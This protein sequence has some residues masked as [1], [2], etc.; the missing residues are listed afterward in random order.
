MQSGRMTYYTEDWGAAGERAV[1]SK[2]LNAPYSLVAGG[3]SPGML[4]QALCQPLLEL[5]FGQAG[6]VAPAEKRIR[7]DIG[8][9]EGR[10]RGCGLAFDF[11]QDQPCVAAR[12]HIDAEV[13]RLSVGVG[14]ARFLDR[15]RIQRQQQVVLGRA[16]VEVGDGGFG[17]ALVFSAVLLS[18]LVNDLVPA[19]G[20][21]APQAQP[22]GRE[23]AVGDAPAA[24][25]RQIGRECGQQ[26]AALDF[27]AGVFSDAV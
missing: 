23:V 25:L 12:E 7:G 27:Q 24:G 10:Q 8:E 22:C 21:H 2:K 18:E 11:C 3:A 13:P 15:Q 20:L 14:V 5:D 9:R 26:V 1:R 6:Q 4:T 19:D 17:C 16:E